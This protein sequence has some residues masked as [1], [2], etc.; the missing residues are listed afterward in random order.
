MRIDLYTKAVLTIIAFALVWLC[1]VLTP[2]GQPIEAQ[3]PPV[4]SRVLITGWVDVAGTVHQM[5]RPANTISGLP[6]A[7]VAG[8]ET[9]AAATPAPASPA[10]TTSSRPA[11][12][13][14]MTAAQQAEW[15]C[16][17][18]PACAKNTTAA[19]TAAAA[20]GDAPRATAKPATPVKQTRVQCQ[21]TT[22]RGAQCRRLAEPG[23]IYCWQHKGRH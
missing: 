16:Q 21:A 15:L 2:I 17:N 9:A 20:S 23:G 11:N 4:G 12:W 22:Q 14:T 8:T 5:P 3:Q 13:N 19:P 1:V 10:A 18:D 7:S 6:V